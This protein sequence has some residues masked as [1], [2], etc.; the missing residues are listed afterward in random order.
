MRSMWRDYFEEK[1]L[2]VVETQRGLISA[3][4]VDDVCMVDNFYVK[5]EYRGT[6]SALQIT[7]QLIKLA[8]DRKC[9]KLCA[10]IYKNDTMYPYILRLHKHFGMEIVEDTEYKTVTSREI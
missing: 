3:Y 10:E 2:V 6:G 8:K 7:L 9:T 1:G 4:I 5:P